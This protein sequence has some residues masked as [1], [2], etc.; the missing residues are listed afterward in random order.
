[1]YII[2]IYILYIYYICILFMCIFIMSIL[3]T[4]KLI[5]YHTQDKGIHDINR[6]ENIIGKL[7]KDETNE[8]VILH[9]IKYGTTNFF[10]RGLM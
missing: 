2:H 9:A 3:I 1:M 5:T 6:G 7:S 10:V 8:N 4:V